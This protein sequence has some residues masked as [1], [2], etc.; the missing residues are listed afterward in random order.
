MSN[1]PTW[2][3]FGR[4]RCPECRIWSCRGQSRHEPPVGCRFRAAPPEPP[5]GCR[6]RAAPPVPPVGCRS[7]AAPPVPPV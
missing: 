3:E 5:V 1:L 6:F 4:E 7:R 2:W